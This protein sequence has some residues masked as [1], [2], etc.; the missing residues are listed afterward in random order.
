MKDLKAILPQLE[1]KKESKLEIKKKG[2]LH[3]KNWESLN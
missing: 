2:N 3:V 1:K